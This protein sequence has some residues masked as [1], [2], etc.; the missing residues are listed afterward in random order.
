VN[1][2]MHTVESVGFLFTLKYDARNHELKISNV[3]PRNYLL[4]YIFIHFIHWSI[5][6]EKVSTLKTRLFFTDFSHINYGLLY[7]FC[8]VSSRHSIVLVMAWM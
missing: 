7:G 4:S 5:R 2:Y 3:I 1:R 6:I 8:S